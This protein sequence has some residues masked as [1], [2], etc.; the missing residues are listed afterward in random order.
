MKID[1]VRDSKL[2]RITNCFMGGR[3]LLLLMVI[4]SC[5]LL[6]SSA[7]RAD[8]F[9]FTHDESLS[10]SIFFSDSPWRDTAN[11]HFLN[12]ML[13]E[14]CLK[15]FGNAEIYL[16]L[17]NIMAHA[18]YLLC[19]ILL[20][21]R[22]HSWSLRIFGF[23]VMNLNLFV[24][25]FFFLARGYGLALGFMMAS[26]VLFLYAFERRHQD[27]S[28]I[29]LLFSVAAGCLSVFAS[30]TL[31]NYLVSLLAV[32]FLMMSI[33][34]RI[35]KPPYYR[36]K[37]L[38][39]LLTVSGVSLY[40]VLKKLFELRDDAQ[41]Y[42]GGSDGF[43]SNTVKS[44]IASSLY[45]GG[46]SD[47]SLITISVVVV[48]FIILLFV[49][50]ARMAMTNR[51]LCLPSMV[52]LIIII[53]VMATI[54]QHYVMGVLFP[55]ERAAVYLLPLTGCAS[56][57]AMDWMSCNMKS[58]FLKKA[59]PVLAVG[60]AAV[61]VVYFFINYGFDKCYTWGYDKHNKNVV[62][63]IRKDAQVSYPDEIVSIGAKF[64]FEPSLNFYRFTNS[65]NWFWPITRDPTN[66]YYYNYIYTFADEITE[67]QLAY[68]RVLAQF[69]DIGTVVL[70]IDPVR[71]AAL[72]RNSTL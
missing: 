46:F 70:G 55:I 32:I 57:L 51:E 34:D 49:V 6:F 45:T 53:A 66:R 3:G 7:Y 60:G 44:L 21:Q 9:P 5:L 47:E 18:V 65:H 28:G 1:R 14:V 52:F 10:F 64:L 72:R 54:A 35:T 29:F 68:Y 58:V 50:T 25:D 13:M 16:R 19:V 31:L 17:P 4:A 40:F 43:V 61:I 39:A 56:L 42:F 69:P 8:T 41:L 11:N 15:L 23:A 38:V 22:L 67:G 33:S 37:A 20:L 71:F 30:F 36:L 48:L 27:I 2:L 59:V 12:T 63:I 24:L 62:E 26:V